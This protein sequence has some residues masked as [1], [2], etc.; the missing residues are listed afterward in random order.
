MKACRTIHA[1]VTVCGT[2]LSVPK[3]NLANGRN[4]HSTRGLGI[5]TE[6]MVDYE[7]TELALQIGSNT[8]QAFISGEKQWHEI[9]LQCLND[10]NLQEI[11]DHR[12]P[13]SVC[14]V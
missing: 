11:W 9:K 10:I 1:H 5:I 8:H 14:L 6:P 12:F 4:Y 7:L 3:P 13:K 2:S